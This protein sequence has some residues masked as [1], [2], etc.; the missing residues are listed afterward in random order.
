VRQPFRHATIL[1]TVARLGSC[2]VNQLAR[3]LSVSDETIR[4]DLKARS[5]PGA[6]GRWSRRRRRHAPIP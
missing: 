5:S 6:F 2:S 4:R 1:E 3:Q